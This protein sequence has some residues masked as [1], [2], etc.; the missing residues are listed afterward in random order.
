MTKQASEDFLLHLEQRLE[1]DET[2]TVSMLASWL[3]SYEPGPR[4]LALKSQVSAKPRLA[5]SH[6]LPS[7]EELL[8]G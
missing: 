3:M 2:A 8:T 7:L 6:G 4:A 1:L 5:K